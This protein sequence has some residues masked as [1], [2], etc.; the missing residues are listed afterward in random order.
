MSGNKRNKEELVKKIDL[1]FQYC[2][3]IN[4]G[5]LA[6]LAELYYMYAD[7]DMTLS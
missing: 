6:L 7:L 5:Q 2:K 1:L 3:C 4:L